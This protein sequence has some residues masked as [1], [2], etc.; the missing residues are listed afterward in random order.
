MKARTW[1][2]AVVVVAAAVW[3]S[4]MQE[5]VSAQ[6]GAGI[7]ISE[8]RFRGARGTSDEFIELFNAGNAPIDVSGWLIRSSTNTNPPALLT[9]ATIPGPTVATPSR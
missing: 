9:V 1:F 6:S 7:V 3:T 5:Q 8:Y 4:P 2:G